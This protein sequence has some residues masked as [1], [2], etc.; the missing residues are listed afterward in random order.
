MPLSK[1]EI[2]HDEKLTP[3]TW[4]LSSRWASFEDAVLR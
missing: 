1:K 3:N 2:L 4:E